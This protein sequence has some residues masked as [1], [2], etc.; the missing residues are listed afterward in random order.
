MPDYQS[1]EAKA[2]M[3]EAQKLYKKAE[4]AERLEAEALR[5]QAVILEKEADRLDQRYK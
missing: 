4:G 1:P 2:K 3:A 5:D